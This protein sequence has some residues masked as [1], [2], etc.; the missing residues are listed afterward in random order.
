MSSPRRSSD[1]PVPFPRSDCARPS[2]GPAP[3]SAPPDGPSPG[4]LDAGPEDVLLLTS[5]PDVTGQVQR[6]AAAAGAQVRVVD[7]PD[8]AVSRWATAAVVLLGVD[9]AA[10]ADERGLPRRGGVHLLVG[11]PPDATVLRAALRV[12]A[13]SVLELPQAEGSLLE[14]LADAAEGSWQDARTIGV[15]GGSGGSG[16]SSLAVTLAETAAAR[17][18]A[19]LLDLDPLGPDLRRTAG[20]PLE[21]LTWRDTTD[22]HGR[23]SARDLRAAMPRQGRLGILGWAERETR[24]P[25]PRQVREVVAAAR[26][27]HAWVVL[28][29]PRALPAEVWPAVEQCDRVVLVVRAT[30]GG[31]ASAARVA[32]LLRESPAP[33]GVVVRRARNRD[34][35]E[36]VA[37][38]L[39]LPLW[40]TLAEHRR[41]DEHLDLG[42]GPA[43]LP[44]CSLARTAGRLLADVERS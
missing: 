20:W 22:A 28:D 32:S 40:G 3:G 18:D 7:A 5:D 17:A 21:G 9:Q 30:V 27:G 19:A 11:G 10:A 34:L 24:L 43:A 13:T 4:S 38:A 16:A 14:L 42:L 1:R 25:A 39:R 36:E 41:L 23:L 6:L 33:V 26:R 37:T 12:G 44:R 2:P 29:L 15:I 8:T 31:V 35:A